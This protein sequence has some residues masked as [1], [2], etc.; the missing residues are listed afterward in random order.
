MTV[1]SVVAMIFSI[2]GSL[3]LPQKQRWG[4]VLWII[5]NFLWIYVSMTTNKD[6]AFIALCIY[7]TILNT[8]T[9]IVWSRNAK[10]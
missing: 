9:L 5:S 1:W 6:Y 8:T 2:A 4:L 10:L 7:N 3:G